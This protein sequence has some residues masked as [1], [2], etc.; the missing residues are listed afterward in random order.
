M[1][2][3]PVSAARRT[4]R[5][6]TWMVADSFLDGMVFDQHS[7]EFLLRTGDRMHVDEALGLR[8]LDLPIDHLPQAQVPLQH[9]DQILPVDKQRLNL[10]PHDEAAN[11]LGTE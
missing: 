4:L 11:D 3:E 2:V 10:F 9:Q 8:G 1:K 5:S 7:L 6:R